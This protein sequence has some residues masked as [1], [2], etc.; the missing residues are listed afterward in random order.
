MARAHSMRTSGPAGE[1]SPA[2][3]KADSGVAAVEFAIIAPVFLMLIFGI[4]IYGIYYTTWI[5]VTQAASEGARASVAGLTNDE[6]NA[7]AT[8]M[9]QSVLTSYAPFLDFSKA[10]VSTSSPSSA[11]DTY[12]VSVS[13]NIFGDSLSNLAGLLPIPS[14]APS[15]TII[16]SNGGY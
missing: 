2:G 6:R 12:Q 4:M 16:V 5:A 9:V 11:P 7:L 15:A 13:Y 3:V 10:T 1:T 14:G 8:G